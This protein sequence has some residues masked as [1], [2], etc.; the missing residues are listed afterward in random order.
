MG[1]TDLG[2]SRIGINNKSLRM[3]LPHHAKR[4]HRGG[5]HRGLDAMLANKEDR[6]NLYRPDIVKQDISFLFDPAPILPNT[7]EEA[8]S[9]RVQSEPRALSPTTTTDNQSMDRMARR[10]MQAWGIN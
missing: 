6:R 1:K 9:L 7:R 8:H 10:L 4:K 2:H 3:D 5:E